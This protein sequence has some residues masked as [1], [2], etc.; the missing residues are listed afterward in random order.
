MI[1]TSPEGTVSELTPGA[2]PENGQFSGSWT[3]RTV[4]SWGEKAAG[5]W[6]LSISNVAEGDVSKCA[7]L[8]DWR[9]NTDVL[10]P[11][12]CGSLEYLE[13]MHDKAHVLSMNNF[14]DRVLMGCCSCGG[15]NA[16]G[17]TCTDF[18]DDSSLCETAE[19][20]KWCVDG[21]L[22]DGTFISL[23]MLEDEEGRRPEDACCILGGGTNYTNP[24]DFQD[25][26]LGWEL[27]VYG[28]EEIIT[29]SPT[30]TSDAV[31]KTLF[32]VATTLL[33]VA[34]SVVR[35]RINT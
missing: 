7:D 12:D 23:L 20:R 28:H 6:T 29:P 18:S 11:V 19:K 32:T 34:C 21:A 14:L 31:S 16:A 8:M 2:I 5:T 33:M 1:L 30:T 15:G 25:L 22:M 3:L 17:N 13:D 10:G 35:I 4:R 26:L 9:V 27:K 24:A